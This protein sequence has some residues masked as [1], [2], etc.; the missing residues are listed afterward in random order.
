MPKIQKA[1]DS[2]T[3]DSVELV[4]AEPVEF[5]PESPAVEPAPQV[6]ASGALFK[7]RILRECAHGKCDDV[8]SLDAATIASYAGTVDADPAAVAYAESL[9]Q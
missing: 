8:V 2:A 3:E 5:A 9:A 6:E 1:A 7:V 4:S